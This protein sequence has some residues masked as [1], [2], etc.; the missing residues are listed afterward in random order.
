MNDKPNESV[1]GYFINKMATNAFKNELVVLR[2]D[3]YID[4]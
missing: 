4:G 1:L 2:F 3:D